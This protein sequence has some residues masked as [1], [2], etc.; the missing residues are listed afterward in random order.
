[1]YCPNCGSADQRSE[2]YCR[3]CRI[4]LPDF[5]KL[6]K[7]EIPPE[8][9][10]TANSVLS[11]MTALVSLTLAILLHI[12]FTGKEGTS[13]LIYVTAGFLTAMFFWQVQT[14]WRT[15]LLKKHFPKRKKAEPVRAESV[16]TN[17]LVESVTTRE[18]LSAPDFAKAVPS[19]VVEDTTKQLRQRLL[20]E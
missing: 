1:M 11:L 4:F 17:P 7:K 20:K 18:L 16:E 3:H 10:L 9:H 2:T 5:E 14:F 15:R 12:F 19:S 13:P 8:Q 6:R